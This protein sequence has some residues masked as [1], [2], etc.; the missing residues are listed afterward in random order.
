MTTAPKKHPCGSCPYRQDVPS[1]LWHPDEY[2][3]LIQYDRP[4]AEQ[5]T[6]LFG[7]HQSDG[8]LCSGWVGTHDMD[9]N[10]AIRIARLEGRLSEADYE[11]T[12]DYESPVPLFESGMEAAVH[13][14]KEVPNP[15]ERAEVMRTSLVRK[16]VAHEY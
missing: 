15:G 9:E 16:G 6:Q 14:I 5:P 8:S 3:R 7:C 1:G 4:T 10:M 12:L 11:A 2:A 13:G